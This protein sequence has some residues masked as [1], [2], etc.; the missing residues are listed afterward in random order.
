VLARDDEEA[1]QGKAA[2]QL[3]DGVTASDLGARLVIHLRPDVPWSDGSRVVAP[4]DVARALTDSALPTSPRYSARWA[5]LL[6]RVETPDESSVE[7]RLTRA[8]LRPSSWLLGPV[9]PAHA[10]ADGRVVTA[11]RGRELVG[12]GPFVLVSA[13]ADR[14]EYRASGR[15]PR[16]ASESGTAGPRVLRVKEV[17]YPDARA[18]LGALRRGD[19]TLVEHVPANRLTELAG[20][21]E[22][23]VGRYQRPSLHRIALDG[24]NPLLRN[25]NLRRGLS[26]AI[27]RRALLEETIL[28][29]PP[30]GANQVSDGVF[31]RGSYADAPDVR[32]L[33]YDPQ[34]GLMLVAAAR[35]ELEGKP[36]KLTLEYPAIPEAQAV[37]PRL[38]EMF[39]VV[40]VEVVAV[41][42]SPSELEAALR[43]GRPFDMAYRATR[44]GEPV[45]DAG[46]LIAPAYDAPPS[47]DPLASLVSPAVLQLLLQLER[48]PEFPT[49]KGLA[50]RIDRESRDELPIL[51][52]WQ[53]EDHYAW[54]TRLKGPK[55]SADGL[56]DGLETWE[57]EP[58]LA[59]DPW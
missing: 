55:E 33:E 48:A 20:N 23:K 57:V 41:E 15:P 31:P 47:A 27:D 25:R 29:R 22:I 49:A 13:A 11:D 35:K 5:D 54:R 19:V 14:A 10:G 52:L 58:W 37:V 28:R 43:S 4:S 24:R 59:R 6:D 40:R 3:A 34:L 38:V 26:Y 21:A 9:G 53:L 2:G 16:G 42:R 7:V 1:A 36:I 56:Y 18:A 30:D 51:P 46:P 44:C 12:D 45:L 39:R 17:R 8:F 50:V 32:P